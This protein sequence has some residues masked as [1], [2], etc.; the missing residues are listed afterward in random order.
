VKNIGES[1]ATYSQFNP[2]VSDYVIGRINSLSEARKLVTALDSGSA[3][4]FYND[5]IRSKKMKRSEAT[6]VSSFLLNR[7][8]SADDNRFAISLDLALYLED[9][10]PLLKVALERFCKLDL[11]SV[12]G[13]SDYRLAS[14][15]EKVFAFGVGEEKY[16]EV[17]NC[18]TFGHSQLNDFYVVLTDVP[19]FVEVKSLL[20]DQIV[21]SLEQ[22]I[23]DIINESDGLDECADE[24]EVVSFAEGCV[25]SLLQDYRMLELRDILRLKNVYSKDSL[26]DKARDRWAS[27]DD[28]VESSTKSWHDLESFSEDDVIKEMFQKFK[29]N[30]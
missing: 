4:M 19:G 18:R 14:I 11:A 15:F 6:S 30:A 23:D 3:V 16:L 2:S 26:I 10:T 29:P 21:D 13:I 24:T 20:K 27:Q 1:E 22:D 5:L 8:L 25:D 7:Y 12:P 28:D 9:E 17:L